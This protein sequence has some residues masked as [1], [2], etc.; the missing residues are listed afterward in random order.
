M[1]LVGGRM[2]CLPNGEKVTARLVAERFI[3]E[4]KRRYRAPLSVDDGGTLLLRGEQTGLTV[5]S[6]AVAEPDQGP[7]YRVHA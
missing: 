1:N 3:M 7:D 5:N 2:C 4:F 6:F